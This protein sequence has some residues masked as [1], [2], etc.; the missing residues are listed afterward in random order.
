MFDFT[1]VCV[2]IFPFP[3]LRVRVLRVILNI[4]HIHS[5]IQWHIVC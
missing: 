2:Y 5:N 1:I 3:L 4:N